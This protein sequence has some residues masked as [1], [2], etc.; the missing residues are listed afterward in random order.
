MRHAPK[1]ILNYIPIFAQT[2]IDGGMSPVMAHDLL[3]PLNDLASAQARMQMF[4]QKYG[5]QVPVM[6]LDST[7]HLDG[8]FASTFYLRANAEVVNSVIAQGHLSLAGMTGF[9]SE[10]HRAFDELSMAYLFAQEDFSFQIN[11]TGT[12]FCV[13]INPSRLISRYKYK[14][15]CGDQNE[16]EDDPTQVGIDE[17][18]QGLAAIS[19]DNHLDYHR[20]L[21][22]EIALHM[23]KLK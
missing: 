16:L 12:R 21:P 7:G 23:F 9:L 17:Q 19:A 3:R 4:L 2:L 15:A 11:E 1:G 8:L 10:S 5:Q 6:K 22:I 14:R 18:V 20:E 13:K